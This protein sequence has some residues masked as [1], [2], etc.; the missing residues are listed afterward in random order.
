MACQYC[1]ER[2]EFGWLICAPPGK[3]SVPFEVIKE[4][5]SLAPKMAVVALGIPHH[6]N[7]GGYHLHVVCA[8]ATPGDVRSW[9]K[10]IAD[11]L[12]NCEPVERWW[13]GTDVGRSAAA[14]FSVF[15]PDQYLKHDATRMGGSETPQ[16]AAD[17]GRCQRLLAQFPEWERRMD[18]AAKQFP[19][20]AWPKI[21]ARWEELKAAQ[22]Q[23]QTEILRECHQSPQPT[24]K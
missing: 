18:E 12:K 4:T 24:G 11:D 10:E 6:Y 5:A 21:I 7:A 15:C 3:D 8:I 9:E 17:L 14:L 23:R 19:N 20:T 16:D 2:H 1:I 13:K 22:P